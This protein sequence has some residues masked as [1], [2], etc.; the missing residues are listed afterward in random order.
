MEYFNSENKIELKYIQYASI[1]IFCYAFGLEYL[2]NWSCNRVTPWSDSLMLTGPEVQGLTDKLGA[3]AT[4]N[5]KNMAQNPTKM[6]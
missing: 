6:Q 3:W 5:C 4:H 1:F 2:M